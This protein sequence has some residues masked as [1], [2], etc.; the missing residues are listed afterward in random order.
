MGVGGQWCGT[1]VSH[2]AW[3]DG[4]R[5]AQTHLDAGGV[6]LG[7]RWRRLGQVKERE[8]ERW[9]GGRGNEEKKK[10]RQKRMEG[11]RG[12]LRW[13]GGCLIIFSPSDLH[14]KKSGRMSCLVRTDNMLDINFLPPYSPLYSS[15]VT[16]PF[17]PFIPLSAF[18][19]FI[20]KSN[21][22]ALT[23]VEIYLEVFAFR[24]WLLSYSRR[25]MLW[26]VRAALFQS[27]RKT[28]TGGFLFPG[29]TDDN[30]LFQTQMGWC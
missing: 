21:T 10:G 18:S 3:W 9:V 5:Q 8:P 17:S 12:M 25:E 29:D 1:D 27:E 28:L 23:T 22:V 16:A 19:P 13:V 7:G 2:H 15:S 26:G 6:Q 11:E 24:C 20:F 14:A 30:L 4:S